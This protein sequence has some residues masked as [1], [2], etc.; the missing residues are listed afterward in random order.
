ML[1]DLPVLEAAHVNNGAHEGGARRRTSPVPLAVRATPRHP[2]PDLV[3]FRDHVLDGEAKGREGLAKGADRPLE[4]LS[5]GRHGELMLNVAKRKTIV[6]GLQ[7]ALVEALLDQTAKDL[8]APLRRRATA[9][10]IH[11]YCSLFAVTLYSM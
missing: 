6:Q 5:R 4:P 9:S 1:G 2:R 10:R 3:P 8:L 7:I 11:A